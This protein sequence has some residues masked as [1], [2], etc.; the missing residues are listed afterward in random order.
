MIEKVLDVIKE[1]DHDSSSTYNPRK[2]EHV[3]AALRNTLLAWRPKKL[4]SRLEVII[5]QMKSLEENAKLKIVKNQTWL[6]SNEGR[7]FSSQFERLEAQKHFLR[8][9]SKTRINLSD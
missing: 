1:T 2:A 9:K 5:Q 7:L 3:I 4:E 6:Q 8:T